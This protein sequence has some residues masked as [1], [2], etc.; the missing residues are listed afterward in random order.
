[1]LSWAAAEASYGLCSTYVHKSNPTR[2][3]QEPQLNKLCDKCQNFTLDP[4]SWP[5]KWWRGPCFAFHDIDG[6]IRSAKEG[7]HVCNLI[8]AELPE[9]K[10]PLMRRDLELNPQHSSKQLFVWVDVHSKRD[11]GDCI[12]RRINLMHSSLSLHPGLPYC[13]IPIVIA[14]MRGKQFESVT[15]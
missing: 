6:L 3:S 2:M 14:D 4:L 1:M 15:R 13:L 7:C 11:R 8:F 12:L 10:L 5:T 9:S